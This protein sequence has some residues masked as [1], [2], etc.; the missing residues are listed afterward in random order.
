M[1]L[2]RTVWLVLLAVALWPVSSGQAAPAG[3]KRPILFS[4]QEA[5]QLRL[6]EGEWQHPPRTRAI[7]LGP[8]IVIQSPQV[9][10]TDAG[11]TIET[12]NPTD[13]S[14]RFE[15]NRSPVDMDSLQIEARKGFFSKSLTVL[16]RPY[17]QGTTLQVTG[18]E[19]PPGRFR[20]EITIADR[21]GAKTV[22]TYR[23]E[24]RGR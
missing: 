2:H 4:T 16:L 20:L 1:R 11:H 17:I 22:E 7:A 9:K 21:N 24:V 6:T 14:V 13:L 12:I 18:A 19:I 15:E 3:K 5:E 23:L 10:E 8:F